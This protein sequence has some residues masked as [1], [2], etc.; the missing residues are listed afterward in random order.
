ML[1]VIRD[2]TISGLAVF[3]FTCIAVTVGLI[4]G[5]KMVM[6][7]YSVISW[8]KERFKKK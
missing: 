3:L 1:E 4:I 5:L 7:M 6:L 2:Y 8:V